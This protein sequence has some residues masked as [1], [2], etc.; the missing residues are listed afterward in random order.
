MKPLYVSKTNSDNAFS[1]PIVWENDFNYLSTWLKDLDM[2]PGKICIVTDSNVANYYLTELKAVLGTEYRHVHSYI[3]PAGESHKNLHEIERLYE[4]LILHHFDRKDMLIALGGGV[5]G[6][7]TGYTAATYL[8][9]IDYI[10]VPTTLLSQVD[11]SVGGKTGVDFKQYKNMVGAFY[12]PRL[13]YMNI[14]TLSTLSKE[15]FISGMGEVV[16]SALIQDAT[17]FE[18]LEEHS[19]EIAGKH[20]EALIHMVY[21]CCKI[22]AAVVEQDPRDTGLRAI[23]NFGHTI[24]HAVEKLSDFSLPHGHCVG[25]GMAG[26]AFLSMQKGMLRHD[27]Y[28]RIIES[29]KPFHIPVNIPEMSDHSALDAAH[30]R[31]AMRSDK[32]V[33]KGT[34]KFILLNHIGEARIDTGI[35]ENE[36][37][38]AILHIL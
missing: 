21:S 34:L 25:I 20:P 12:Q 27:E 36:I 9:G 7:M 30:I 8:R 1:Y 3:L 16:K 14:N 26:A 23:L 28:N 37:S 29:L 35:T 2:H 6:D 32:K 31:E 5:T 22:K 4:Y 18:W 33:E 11:S 24:G 15:Q 13:V 17:F 19:E 10:Q 38:A